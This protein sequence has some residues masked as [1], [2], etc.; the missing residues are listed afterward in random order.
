MWMIRDISVHFWVHTHLHRE[1]GTSCSPT[2]SKCQGGGSSSNVP[3]K[4]FAYLSH[5]TVP[6]WL[7]YSNRRLSAT[8]NPQMFYKC[9]LFKWL[10]SMF[11]DL[12]VGL[13]NSLKEADCFNWKEI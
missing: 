5:T 9:F 12:N 7:S 4:T 11:L 2:T 13:K 10:K 1:C 6:S 3:A 8:D